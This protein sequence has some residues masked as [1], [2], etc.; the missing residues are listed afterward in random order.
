MLIDL[1]HQETSAIANKYSFI[2][3]KLRKKLIKKENLDEIEETAMLHALQVLTENAIG[4]AKHI[5]KS[6]NETVP[7]SAY[8]AVQAVIRLGYIAEDDKLYWNSIIGVRNRIVHDYMNVDA[9][10]LTKLV[11]QEH[12]KKLVE[13]LCQ[14]FPTP[15]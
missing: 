7:V 13:F 11:A 4:K 15:K 2:L 3:Q 1:Y 9:G 10:L 8:D 12:E 5:L 6:A 14:K